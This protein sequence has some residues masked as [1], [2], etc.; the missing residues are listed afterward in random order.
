MKTF[1]ARSLT[2]LIIVGVVLSVGLILSFQS[3]SSSHASQLVA[4]A[5][6]VQTGVGSGGRGP[7]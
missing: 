7:G 6:G 3:K 1:G 2:K 5:G 4:G